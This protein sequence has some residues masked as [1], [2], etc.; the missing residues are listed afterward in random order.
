MSTSSYSSS[1]GS[2][3]LSPVNKVGGAI[4][5]L[6][7][8]K[9]H[10]SRSQGDIMKAPG[11]DGADAFACLINNDSSTAAET[12]QTVQIKPYLEVD[13]TDPPSTPEDMKFDPADLELPEGW[14][15]VRNENGTYFW[16]VP[17]GTTQW[18]R[19]QMVPR[20][21]VLLKFSL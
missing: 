13:I 4:D 16:H 17:T 15:E 11:I 18:E 3:D 14:R 2:D 20:K 6:K 9:Q 8:P 7:G 12:D 21:K 5:G 19:P 1:S 10:R